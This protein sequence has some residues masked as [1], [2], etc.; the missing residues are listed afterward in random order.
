[1]S[2]RDIEV[3]EEIFWDYGVRGE[4]ERAVKQPA[5]TGPQ[6]KVRLCHSTLLHNNFNMPI[7]QVAAEPLMVTIAIPK[8]DYVLHNHILQI[9]DSD[10]I[11]KEERADHN[12]GPSGLQVS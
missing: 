3:G 9:P 1:M 8:N 5:P 10:S 4:E 2:V 11:G 7:S 12:P 6:A